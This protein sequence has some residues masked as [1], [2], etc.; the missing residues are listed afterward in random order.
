VKLL[1]FLRGIFMKKLFALLT[2]AA[3]LFVAGD[4]IAKKHHKGHKKAAKKVE[5]PAPAAA[6]APAATK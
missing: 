4:A 1:N 2:V 3:F 5:Q 6:E